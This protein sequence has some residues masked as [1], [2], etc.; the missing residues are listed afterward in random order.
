MQDIKAIFHEKVEK[1]KNVIFICTS[2]SD[3]EKHNKWAK[4]ILHLPKNH[5]RMFTS[6]IEYKL[7]L[8][9]E[10]VISS[11]WFCH[12]NKFFN[13][14][15]YQGERTGRD[16]A[17]REYHWRLQCKA[18]VQAMTGG[19]AMGDTSAIWWVETS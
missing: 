1:R 19:I 14:F 3:F 11:D 4:I 7:D 5:H 9:F 6:Q 12:V 2:F 8:K 15:R 18:A 17:R 16:G 10:I 13:C